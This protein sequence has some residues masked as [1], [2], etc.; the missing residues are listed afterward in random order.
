MPLMNPLANFN[1][2]QTEPGHGRRVQQNGSTLV[3][4]RIILWTATNWYLRRYI[5]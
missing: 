3:L 4:T 5:D 2:S 1:Q